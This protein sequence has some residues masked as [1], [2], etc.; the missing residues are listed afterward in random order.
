MS[1]LR[2]LDVLRGLVLE[3]DHRWGEI[4]TEHQLGDAQAVLE[5]GDG[6]RR[7]WHGRARG[8]S[9]TSDVA[10]MSIAALLT[11]FRA[12]DAAYA[13]AG[14]RDQAGLLLAAA[15][16]FLART[17]ELAGHLEVQASRLVALRSGAVLEVLSADAATS[18]GL[19][20][21]W[22]VVDE[23]CQWPRTPGAREFWLALSTA[24]PKVPTSR[25]IVITTAGD[26]AHWS[27]KVY[28]AAVAEPELWRVSETHGPAPWMSP[29][30]V[31]F[32]RKRL[33]PSE[34]ARLFLNEWTAAEDA[35]V[36]SDDLD[37]ACTLNGPLGPVPGRSY[38]ITLDVGLTNDAT[39]AVVAHAEP[40]SATADPGSLR[41]VVDRMQVW[42][43][44]KAAPVQLDEVAATLREWSAGY[45][46]A[47]VVFDPFQAVQMAQQLRT[48]GVVAD[49]F[50]FGSTSV[51]RLASSLHALLRQRLIDLPD[52]AKLR[53]ELLAV[54][55]RTNSAGIVRLDH[56]SSGHDDRAVAIALAAVTLLERPRGTAT[57]FFNRIAPPCPDCGTPVPKSRGWCVKCDP[58]GRDL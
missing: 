31:E 18:W 17:P 27:H 21:H 42:Q 54:R 24:L 52:D 48:V 25:A 6:P 5:P 7:H 2:A 13:A 12:G 10:G 26:P 34:F 33:L 45:Y 29:R 51:G 28:E 49:A 44:T 47:R 20:P 15:R 57:A 32:E 55:L 41:V 11:Q 43:G 36:D 35:L 53:A 22:L 37:A 58:P 40:A 1:E 3:S 30:E 16:G 14:D 8:Y 38:V 9:K 23:L 46:G 56:S 39:V 4:A 50:T 19:L